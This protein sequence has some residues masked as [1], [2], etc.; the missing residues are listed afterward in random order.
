VLMLG[1]VNNVSFNHYGWGLCLGFEWSEGVV[2]HCEGQ[3][4]ME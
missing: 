2:R 3:H 4:G 1:S